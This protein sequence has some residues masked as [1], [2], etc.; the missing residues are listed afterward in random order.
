MLTVNQKPSE[1]IALVANVDPDAY[2][3][4]SYDSG[5]VDASKFHQ[6]LAVLQMGDLGSSATVLMKL[7]QASNSGGTGAEDITGK[8]TATFTQAG[9]DYSNKQALLHL[10]PDEMVGALLSFKS[11]TATHIRVRVTVGVATSDVGA[12]LYGINPRTGVA[13]DHDA[14]SVASVG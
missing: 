6:F 4:N 13:T 3:A 11:G 7:Q 5:W 14:S 1:G 2:A 8:V 9:T 10:R 12:A